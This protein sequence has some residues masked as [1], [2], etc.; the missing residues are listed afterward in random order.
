MIATYKTRRT[1]EK[2]DDEHYLLYLNEQ[3]VK[4]TEPET[5]ETFDGYSYDGDMCDG[6]TKIETNDIT[7]DNK[8][9]KFI[10]GLIGCKYSLDAQ[11]AIL[12]NGNDT[13]EHAAELEAFTDYRASCKTAIDALL[14]R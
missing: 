1:F 7:D 11:I 10:T 5:N 12:A 13:P 9:S 6:S 2:Y 4:A 14:A 8:R 3:E